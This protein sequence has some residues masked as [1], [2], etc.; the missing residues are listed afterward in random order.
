M[1]RQYHARGISSSSSAFLI[2]CQLDR[3]LMSLSAVVRRR[4]CSKCAKTKKIAGAANMCSAIAA[5]AHAGFKQTSDA[6]AAAAG[7]F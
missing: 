2:G 7:G 4:M 6:V 5:V 1:E 3:S